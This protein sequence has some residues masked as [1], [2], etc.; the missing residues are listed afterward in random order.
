M[1]RTDLNRSGFGERFWLMVCVALGLAQAWIA[2]NSMTGDGISYLDNGDA[3]FRRDWAQAINGYWS[4]MYSWCLGLGMH[5]LK[6]SIWWE[7]IAVHAVNLVIYFFA[8]VCFRFFLHA[9]I[10][11]LR[12]EA[13]KSGAD[14]LPL[15]EWILMS[16]GYGIFLWAALVL[17][18]VGA[19][20]PDLLTAAFLFL[21]GGYLVELRDRESYANFAVFGIA[22]GL[23]YLSKAV[24]FP[25]GFL[26]LTILLFSGKLSTRRVVG[27]CGAGLL[28]LM[29]S[30]PFIAALSMQKG[31]LT[32]GESGR[33]AYAGMVN[34]GVPPV[35]W[36]GEEEGAGVP[37]H[38]TRQ[39]LNDPPVYEFA[40]PVGGTFPP[41]YD[42][43][44]WNDGVHGVFRWRAQIRVLLQS[45]RNYT[46]ILLGELGLLAGIGTLVLWGG[47]AT[48]KAI[49]RNWPLLVIAIFSMGLY[50]VVLVRSRYVGAF[51]VFLLMA[52]VAGIRLPR[53]ADTAAA[54]Y[55]V[56]AVMGTLLFS[57]VA[58]LAEAAYM[59]NTAYGYPMQKEEIRAATALQSMGLRSGDRV[60]VIGD[61]R[62]DYW[63]RLGRFK[64]VAEVSSPGAGN[65]QFWSEP[66][67]RR[68]LAYDN[69][70]R[71]GAKAVVVWAV[72]ASA[73]AGWKQIP[74]TNYYVLF[75]NE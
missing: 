60:A 47:R 30:S 46:E 18:D 50:S 23:A 14:S 5:L 8:L 36:Q 27:A 20:T 19:P 7:F 10:R 70:A 12:S 49:L 61:G 6:P 1:Q 38:A 68:K 67:E 73:D 52:I 29:V 17:F 48:R 34:P 13:T 72:P 66:F 58:N 43:S 28:F 4:P 24:M 25:L 75:L 63:A 44:Y 51:F 65:R 33:I 74:A 37:K 2:R 32:F 56:V 16:L 71:S 39:L 11:G 69:L 21:I 62:R 64:I 55:V 22:C 26:F 15:P 35:H 59:N 54:K 41:W 40:E 53:S 9:I 45:A 31:R 3:Y 42:P 57:F